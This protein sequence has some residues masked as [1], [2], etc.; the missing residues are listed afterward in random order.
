MERK[1]VMK[2]RK[3]EK[4]ERKKERKS[5]ITIL[6]LIIIFIN[7]YDVNKQEFFP[8]ISPQHPPAPS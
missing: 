4:M 2:Q 5:Y 7:F 8:Q 1:N 3:T 6:C